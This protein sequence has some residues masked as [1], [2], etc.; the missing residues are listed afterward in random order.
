MLFIADCGFER[1]GTLLDLLMGVYCTLRTGAQGSFR[2]KGL[3]GEY[4][5]IKVQKGQ[6]ESHDSSENTHKYQKS[7][8][9]FLL[10]SNALYQ[11]HNRNIESDFERQ[12]SESDPIE[13][14]S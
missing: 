5:G 11:I 12:K 1:S 8:L 10:L 9:S 4:G 2:K 14:C 7:I 13:S 3:T 6:F